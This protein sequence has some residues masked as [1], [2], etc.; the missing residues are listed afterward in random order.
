M[1]I[2]RWVAFYTR[3]L[4]PSIAGERRDEIASDI[5]EQSASV[6]PGRAARRL[7]ALSLIWRSIRGVASDL[8]WRRVQVRQHREG[9]PTV[10]TSTHRAWPPSRVIPTAL[11]LALGTVG[12]LSA[13]RVVVNPTTQTPAAT[14]PLLIAATAIL[15]AGLALHVRPSSG[16]AG[17]LVMAVISIPLTWSVGLA[18]WSISATGADSL[19]R[20]LTLFDLERTQNATYLITAPGLGLALV[21]LVAAALTRRTAAGQAATEGDSRSGSIS[22]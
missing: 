8:T 13:M 19:M 5:H 4:P 22:A 7:L 21:F 12:A 10:H 20:L 3:N 6:G 18:I 16:T 9:D 17:L 15:L 14:A 2:L 1:A 11:A